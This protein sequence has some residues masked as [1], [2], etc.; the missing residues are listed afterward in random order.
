MIVVCS[1][2]SWLSIVGVEVHRRQ[3][4]RCW[5]HEG[6]DCWRSRLNSQVGVQVFVLG[7]GWC[8]W[9]LGTLCSVAA[10]VI[11]PFFVGVMAPS[12]WVRSPTIVVQSD[13]HHTLLRVVVA[14]CVWEVVV[15]HCAWGL[16]RGIRRQRFFTITSRIAKAIFVPFIYRRHYRSSQR[17]RAERQKS[18]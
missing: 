4:W 3:A 10:K 8:E 6:S 17:W 5:A 2:C 14:L 15:R 12:L 1:I 18:A 11:V 7:H 9:R 13:R 16:A